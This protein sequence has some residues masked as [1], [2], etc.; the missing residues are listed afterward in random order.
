MQTEPRKTIPIET[1]QIY[2]NDKIRRHGSK[3]AVARKIGTSASRLEEY[4]TGVRK[5]KRTVTKEITCIKIDVADR[6]AIK[7]DDHLIDVDPSLY[8]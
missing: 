4:L 1:F 6:I 8:E 2:L 3:E 7:L 5:D